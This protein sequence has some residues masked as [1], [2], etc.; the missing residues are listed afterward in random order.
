[1]IFQYMQTSRLKY[2]RYWLKTEKTAL[3]ISTAIFKNDLI[4]SV[5]DINFV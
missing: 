2:E 3:L 1:M 5:K 4:E